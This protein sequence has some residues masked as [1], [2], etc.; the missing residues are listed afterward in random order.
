VTG[1][2]GSSGTAE[3]G[4]SSGDGGTSTTGDA[5]AST[6][7]YYGLC[8]ACCSGN[9]ESIPSPK[10]NCLYPIACTVQLDC[11]FE[12]SCVG[13]FCRVFTSQ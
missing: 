8:P 1:S 2:A 13:G 10:A 5:G 7:D 3:A 6:A 4:A 11:P 9:N 12:A